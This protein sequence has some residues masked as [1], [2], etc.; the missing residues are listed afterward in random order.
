MPPQFSYFMMK[1]PSLQTVPFSWLEKNKL[2]RVVMDLFVFYLAVIAGI[3][4]AACVLKWR[5]FNHLCTCVQF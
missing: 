4:T 1:R 3:V 5:A 2:V